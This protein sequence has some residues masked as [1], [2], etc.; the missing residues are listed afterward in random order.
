MKIFATMFMAL[1]LASAGA[2]AQDAGAKDFKERCAACHK[3]ETV[4]NFTKERTAWLEKK[5]STHQAP[6]AAQRPRISGASMP[7]MRTL[8]SMSWPTQTRA[9]TI[10][11]S[12]SSTLSTRPMTGPG[13]TSPAGTGPARRSADKT[14]KTD[15]RIL[16]THRS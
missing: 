4:L 1:L 13:S 8:I 15:T 14:A 9:R 11:V 7:L 10:I 6:D 3:V 12:P 2:Q 16:I 5:L